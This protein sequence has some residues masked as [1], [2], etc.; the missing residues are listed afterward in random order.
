MSGDARTRS[1]SV[2]DFVILNSMGGSLATDESRAAA[3]ARRTE[4]AKE[5]QTEEA[6][7]RT[8]VG[9]AAAKRHGGRGGGQEGGGS[10]GGGGQAEE[11]AKRR[12]RP[13]TQIRGQEEAKSAR[14]RAQG[15]QSRRCAARGCDTFANFGEPA[16]KPGER[17]RALFCN[18]HRLP[19][20]VNVL[21]QNCQHE[22]CLLLSCLLLR[23]PLRSHAVTSSVYAG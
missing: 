11:S 7:R 5:A 22:V 16:A 19:H 9:S 3:K 12:G 21:R 2:Q 17:G 10:G 15:L 20:H 1:P 14:Q 4:V 13:R 6:E 23:A 18:K 8:G